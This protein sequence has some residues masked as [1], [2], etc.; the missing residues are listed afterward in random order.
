MPQPQKHASAAERQA[1][2]RA[3][4]E[5]AR[6]KLSS[7]K[8]LPSLPPVPTI[9]GWP[10]WNAIFKL[11]HALIE[12]AVSE[13]LDY[14]EDRSDSWKE[15]ERGEEHQERTAGAEAVLEALG[16]LIP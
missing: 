12:G 11:A 16:E 14:F 1:A 10:R 7:A 9:P 15:S 3:R 6:Q 8:G 2:Y 5:Q 4:S 13:Q